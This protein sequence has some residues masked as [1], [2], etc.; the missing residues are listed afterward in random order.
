[1]LDFIKNVGPTEL[2]VVALILLL[3][4]GRKVLVGIARSAG[5]TL[6][7]VKKIKTGFT[8]VIEDAQKPLDHEKEVHH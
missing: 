7:E 8:D 3:L 6:R 1:M 2:I 4:F 5:E